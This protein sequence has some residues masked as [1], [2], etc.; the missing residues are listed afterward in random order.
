[1]N[2]ARHHHRPRCRAPSTRQS[3]AG[4]TLLVLLLGLLLPGSA[5]ATHFRYAKFSWERP[6]P[7]N[8]PYTVEF[9]LLLATRGSATE[10][11]LWQYEFRFGDGSS[12]YMTNV[13][14]VETVA[15]YLD[16]PWEPFWIVRARTSHTYS[17]SSPNASY[18]VGIEGCCR[19]IGLE[20]GNSEEWIILQGTVDFR[21]GN[22]A[23]PVSLGPTKLNMTPN[24]TQTIEIP[25]YDADGEP[26]SCRLASGAESGLVTNPP[27]NWNTSGAPL[28]VTSSDNLC[29]LTWDPGGTPVSTGLYAIALK[30]M[31]DNGAGGTNE[32]PLDLLLE[33]VDVALPTCDHEDAVDH[34]LGEGGIELTF[35]GQSPGAEMQFVPILW[36]DDGTFSVLADTIQAAPFEVSFNWTPAGS[37]DVGQHSVLA[38]FN[39]L[40]DTYGFITASCATSVTVELFRPFGDID[41][42]GRVDASDLSM[43]DDYIY[44]RSSIAP[45]CDLDSDGY[46]TIWD[47]RLIMLEIRNK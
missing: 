33:V 41:G 36:P 29:T 34:V 43:L 8:D 11:Y 17:P 45:S 6:D 38:H 10:P 12:Y 23:G 39:Q 13:S 24:G 47:T 30:M 32:T 4:I 5:A 14:K 31:S 7:L 46:L 18:T 35:T 27:Q 3:A 20:N 2:T 25:M 26:V 44:P 15:V 28:A 22:T 42:N 37:E 21:A 16:S 40:D 19:L 9:D 1:M